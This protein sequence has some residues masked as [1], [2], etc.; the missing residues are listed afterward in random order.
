MNEKEYVKE[1][2]KLNKLL[3]SNS[4]CPIDKLNKYMNEVEVER[5]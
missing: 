2:K 5:E 1:F 4:E 3:K